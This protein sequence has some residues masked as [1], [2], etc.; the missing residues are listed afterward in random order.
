MELSTALSIAG[1]VFSAVNSYREGQA[2]KVAADSQAAQ[3]R[4][5]AGQEAAMSQR[6][7][8][9]QRRKGAYAMSRARAVAAASGGSVLDPSVLNIMGDIESETESNVLNAL[10][11][12]KERA[13]GLNYQADMRSFEGKQAAKAGLVRATGTILSFAGGETG[14]SLLE[15]YSP[16]GGALSAVEAGDEY[17]NNQR[18][19]SGV[20]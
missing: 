8:I 5:Q 17:W 2:A 20:Y 12:G 18:R 10:Y 11:T 15:K 19:M 16:T 13:T 6:D 3:L 1:T 4:Q 14:S 9:L 7:A